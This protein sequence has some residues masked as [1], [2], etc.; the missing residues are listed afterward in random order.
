MISHI[1]MP[2]PAIHLLRK[3]LP[4]CQG[5]S[6]DVERERLVPVRQ[7]KNRVRGETL[8]D[9]Q[10][11]GCLLGPQGRPVFGRSNQGRSGTRGDVGVGSNHPAPGPSTIKEL[12]YL[13]MNAG[14]KM[15]PSGSWL[16]TRTFTA[17]IL[18]TGWKD[19]GDEA[20]SQNTH[21][22]FLTVLRIGLSLIHI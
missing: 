7:N 19:D 17:K 11:G 21:R 22:W 14:P 8:D 13:H 10:E 6:V 3:H 1:S 2:A 12:S 20:R 5:A 18:S 15:R 4:S 16:T 9:L